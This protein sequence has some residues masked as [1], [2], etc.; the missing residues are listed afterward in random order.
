MSGRC[1]CLLLPLHKAHNRVR[2][3]K[4]Y[5]LLARDPVAVGDLVSPRRPLTDGTCHV[6]NEK[7]VVE[8]N[9]GAVL[10]NLSTS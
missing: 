7:T 1:R 4:E 6:V 3:G 9:S 5:A 8:P 2:E 10:V